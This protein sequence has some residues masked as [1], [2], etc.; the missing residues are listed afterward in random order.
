MT[1]ERVS[2]CRNEVETLRIVAR[3][4]RVEPPYLLIT[5]S[6][7]ALQGA[8]MDAPRGRNV[9]GDLGRMAARM[10]G[11]DRPGRMG[12]RPMGTRHNREKEHSRKPH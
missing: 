9:T 7:A 6:T 1:E 2:S 4:E 12:A 10:V 11:C 8:F 3:E 5:G